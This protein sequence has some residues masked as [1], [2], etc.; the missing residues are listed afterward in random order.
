MAQRQQLPLPPDPG[1]EPMDDGTVRW[2]DESDSGLPPEAPEAPAP[3]EEDEIADAGTPE[4]GQMDLPAE[5]AFQVPAGQDQPAVDL[6]A[7]PPGGDLS[8]PD[9]QEPSPEEET[10]LPAD[11]EPPVTADPADSDG[12]LLPPTD[13]PGMDGADV[14]TGDGEPLDL[15]DAPES[16]EAP[17]QADDGSDVELPPEPGGQAGGA[18]LPP[19]AGGP[20]SQPLPEALSG[21]SDGEKMDLLLELVVQMAQ[22]LDAIATSGVFIRA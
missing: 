9:T 6:L 10:P 15:P 12:E 11:P 7:M 18:E 20:R 14:T 5:P 19:D 21:M 2:H 16:P 1:D 8:I 22:A 13:P 3:P 4:D 17:E